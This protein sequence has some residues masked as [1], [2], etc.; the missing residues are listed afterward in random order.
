MLAVAAMMSAT[1]LAGT[2]PAFIVV[3]CG[4]RRRRRF[5]DAALYD[6]V[7]FAPVEPDT[8]AI[9]AKIDLDPL[10]V[11][12]AQCDIANRAAHGSPSS[13]ISFRVPARLRQFNDH[14]AVFLTFAASRQGYQIP[15]S[16]TAFFLGFGEPYLS[17][18]AAQIL[19]PDTN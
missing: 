3:T 13:C 5:T 19:P 2:V 17:P 4:W 15:L 16:T 11:R 1:V 14:L 9:G 7:K 6:L 8:P 10:S 18:F 12:H